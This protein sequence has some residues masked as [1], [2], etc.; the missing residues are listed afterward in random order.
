MA[1]AEK[2]NRK[3]DQAALLEVFANPHPGRDYEIEHIAPE[4]TSVCPKTGQPDFGVI[5][6]IY[7]PDKKCVEL[8]SWK[9]YLQSYR[10]R[11]IFYEDVTNVILNDLTAVLAPRTMTVISE[12]T[13]RGGIRS[14]IRCNYQK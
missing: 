1:K 7:T 2:P 8:K 13:P 12:W 3:N 14:V 5:R 11:G 10:N 9:L 6:L 4:F